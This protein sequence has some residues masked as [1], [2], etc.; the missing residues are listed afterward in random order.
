[1]IIIK[2]KKQYKKKK[3]INIK[4]KFIGLLQYGFFGLQAKTSG[5][6][7]I[8]QLENIRRIFIKI[9]KRTAKIFIRVFF[10]KPK[11][12]KPLLSRMGKGVGN[13]NL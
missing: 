6:L 12:A 11:T 9:S 7:D 2:Y 4:K 8:K 13:I 10:E 3:I 5:I 1:M